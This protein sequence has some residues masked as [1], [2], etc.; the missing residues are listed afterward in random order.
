M[1]DEREEDIEGIIRHI[2]NKIY[3]KYQY[4]FPYED[5][6]DMAH[7][8]LNYAFKYYDPEKGRG[9]KSFATF[10]VTQ[11]IETELRRNKYT[12]T[13][14]GR[15]EIDG[16]EYWSGV[17]TTNKILQAAEASEHLNWLLENADLSPNEKAAM[18]YRLEGLVYAEIGKLLRISTERSRQVINSARRKLRLTHEEEI[19][20]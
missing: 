8:G 2:A 3:R 11:R 13:I 15:V 14:V 7:K 9:W 18:N 1:K 16:L 4:I 17:P 6:I 19:Y 20:A 12:K 10:V 5:I